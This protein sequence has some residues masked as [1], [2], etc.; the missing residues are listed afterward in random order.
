MSVREH[1]DTSPGIANY[2]VVTVSDTRTAENDTGG[3]TVISMMNG[4]G[5]HLIS[6]IIVKDDAESIRSALYNMLNEK[7]DV[8]IFTGGTGITSRDITYESVEPELNKKIPGFGELF[9]FLSYQEIGSAAMMSRAFAGVVRGK[10][11]FCLPGSPD[12]VRLAMDRLILPE[13][14]HAIREARR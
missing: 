5:H 13:I 2:T 8:I 14:G 3:E 12:G 6:R 4:A 9:R 11:V 7:C 10:V 1:R